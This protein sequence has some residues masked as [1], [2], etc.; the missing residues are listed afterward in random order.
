MSYRPSV[1]PS[2]LDDARLEE[3]AISTRT[4]TSIFFDG[5]FW[6]AEIERHGETQIE[7]ARHCFGPEPTNA[8]LLEWVSQDMPRLPFHVRMDAGVPLETRRRCPKKIRRMV[9]A[10]TGRMG[11]STKAQEALKAGMEEWK[12]A[13]RAC[14]RTCRI[15]CRAWRAGR[16]PVGALQRRIG[17]SP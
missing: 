3:I 17:R 4:I 5:Q 14:E 16:S 15:H 13:R 9:E 7:V 12:E 11:F 1:R 8:E 6:V 2:A 10:E